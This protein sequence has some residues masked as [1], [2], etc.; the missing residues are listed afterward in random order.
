MKLGRP[1]LAKKDRRKTLS[2]SL[3]R[4]VAD[5]LETVAKFNGRGLSRTAEAAIRKALGMA[6]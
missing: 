1:K 2:L 4:D 5:R 3:S 6:K